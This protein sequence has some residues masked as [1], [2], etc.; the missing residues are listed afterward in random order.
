MA[1]VP[2]PSTPRTS[3]KVCLK[4]HL[5]INRTAEAFS[6]VSC[7]R[8]IHTDHIKLSEKEVKH[9]QKGSLPFVYVCDECK[10]AFNVTKSSEASKHIRALAELNDQAKSDFNRVESDLRR[11]QLDLELKQQEAEQL[12]NENE[13]IRAKAST[14]GTKNKRQ[15]TDSDM[16]VN[17]EHL[18][19]IDQLFKRLAD[20]QADMLGNMFNQAITNQQETLNHFR[21]SV[22]KRLTTM[23][24]AITALQH[25]PHSARK[26]NIDTDSVRN[27]SPIRNRSASRSQR[28]MPLRTTMTYA[29][30]LSVSTTP[31]SAIRSVNILTEND[32]QVKGLL[33]QLRSDN[34][35]AEFDVRDIVKKSDRTLIMKCGDNES[36][37]KV[38]KLLM[39]KY[40][41]AIEIKRIE[42]T[43]PKLKFARLY[44][45]LDNFDE[46]IAQIRDQNK[47]A[48]N[49]EMKFES[50][51]TV[52]SRRGEYKNL[53]VS[54][55]LDSFLVFMKM[56]KI[57]F[58]F[59]TSPIYENV[60][61]LQCSRCLRFA[62]SSG[63]C[64]GK[65]SCRKCG[66]EHLS[67][68]CTEEKDR[69]INCHRANEKGES[70]NTNHKANDARC[71]VRMLRIDG[72]KNH[73]L[74]SATI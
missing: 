20:H 52:L 5:V 2:T 26:S 8:Y 57:I 70:F 16:E 43:P 4:C 33:S 72:L 44:T 30:A 36:A 67:K 6:C 13:L 63:H 12:K 11:I 15:R 45:S 55:T 3:K 32:E 64:R 31:V 49:L 71:P 7:S 14:S 34:A 28:T 54:T 39:D 59:S 41:G 68:D 40:K 73:I 21:D 56:K 58:G 61:V 29:E 1:N 74:N 60:N 50:L 65:I 35:C 38:G 62:H 10:V 27:S 46:I 22:D 23:N 17:D 66:S 53:N 51:D 24:D 69:C 48:Q 37:E 19:T 18:S 9:I 42:P 25:Q 47:W